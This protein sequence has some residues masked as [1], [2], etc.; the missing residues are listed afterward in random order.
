VHDDPEATEEGQRLARERRRQEEEAGR[1][2]GHRDPDEQ[3]GRAGA[4]G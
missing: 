1:G 4:E 3:A 2:P